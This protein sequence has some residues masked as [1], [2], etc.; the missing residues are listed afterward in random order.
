[1][2]HYYN[3]LLTDIKNKLLPAL[4]H[5]HLQYNIT[6]QT[7]TLDHLCIRCESVDD[8]N[9][10]LQEFLTKGVIEGG[11]AVM[12][13]EEGNKRPIATV[14]LY[15][16]IETEYGLVRF[17]E[18]ASP[19]KGNIYKSGLEHIEWTVNSTI[20]EFMKKFSYIK[21]IEKGLNKPHH[22]HIEIDCKQEYGLMIKFNTQTI[23]DQIAEESKLR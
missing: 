5:I 23:E 14:R 7:Y 20:E 21:F 12:V 4:D 3:Q 17:I 2:T 19:K 22:P 6:F 10:I 18:I 16:P 15:S 11:A 8:Y 1:M 13:G 9:T